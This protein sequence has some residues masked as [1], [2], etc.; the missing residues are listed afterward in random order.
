MPAPPTPERRSLSTGTP[1]EHAY[2]YRRAVRH[3]PFV[4]VAGTTGT[5]DAGRVSEP[6]D[7]AAQA[8]RALAR[9]EAALH[10]LGATLA[11]VVRTR[12]YVTDIAR[13]ADAVGR[14]HGEVF[15]AVPHPPATTM[16]EVCA[17]IAPE[18]RVEIEAE[19]FVPEAAR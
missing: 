7:A 4:W 2:A 17:L 1:W 12:L 18:M 19:A 5:D 14:V 6:D 15:G 11:D 8:R 16:V 13:D 10:G 9:I 3:G